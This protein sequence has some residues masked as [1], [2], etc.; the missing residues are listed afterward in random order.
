MAA[1]ALFGD[2]LGPLLDRLRTPGRGGPPPHAPPGAVDGRARRSRHTGGAP[3][4]G[5]V[6][7]AATAIWL[8]SRA[9]GMPPP[10]LSPRASP[11][12]RVGGTRVHRRSRQGASRSGRPHD[13]D[14]RETPSCASPPPSGWV[15]CGATSIVDAGWRIVSADLG[16]RR[17]GRGG[18]VARDLELARGARDESTARYGSHDRPPGPLTS[19]AGREREVRAGRHARF[20]RRWLWRDGSPN[21]CLPTMRRIPWARA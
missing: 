19:P 20:A 9:S 6:A 21:L 11:E 14:L 7:P 15:R 8:R 13:A 18:A 10:P 5:R 2:H 16:D 1:R 3:A 12:Y 17:G 4:S